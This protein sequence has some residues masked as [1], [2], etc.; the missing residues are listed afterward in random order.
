MHD[1]GESD[2]LLIGRC[3]DGDEEAVKFL[4]EKYQKKIFA[5]A[6][7]LGGNNREIAYDVATSGFVRA[8]RAGASRKMG[9]TFLA[10]LINAVVEDIQ[11][12]EIIAT[13]GESGFDLEGIPPIRRESL[14]LVKEALQKLPLDV[15]VL[16]LLRDQLHLRHSAIAAVFKSTEASVKAQ[17]IEARTLLRRKIKEQMGGG[18]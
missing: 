10:R 11:D 8:I 16:L 14:R 1:G 17:T 12:R 9:G 7:L 18:G 13:S 15:K 2:D 4:I 6:L 5:L 3:R